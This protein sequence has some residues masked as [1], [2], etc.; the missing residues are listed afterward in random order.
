M[1][2]LV[3][4]LNSINPRLYIVTNTQ[5]LDL[6]IDEHVYWNN[7]IDYVLSNR[8]SAYFAVRNLRNYVGKQYLLLLGHI[9]T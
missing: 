6:H 9:L 7:Y 2:I 5:F 8:K 4:Y 3:F 1:K